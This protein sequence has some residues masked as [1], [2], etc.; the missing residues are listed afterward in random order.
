MEEVTVPQALLFSSTAWLVAAGAGALPLV[1]SGLMTPLDAYF[2]SM[3]GF[4]A[5]GMTLISRLEEVPRSILL[6]RSMTQWLGGVGVVL[7]FILLVAP[8]GICV[9]ALCG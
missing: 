1:L 7:F 6:W 2:E 9:E 8:R 3:S 4:T 5:T